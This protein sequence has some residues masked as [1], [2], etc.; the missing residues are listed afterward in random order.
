M[1]ELIAGLNVTTHRRGPTDGDVLQ[2]AALLRREASPPS[3]E[4]QRP[5]RPSPCRESRGREIGGRGLRLTVITPRDTLFLDEE[6]KV[7]PDL[8]GAQKLGELTEML[9]EPRRL[10]QRTLVVL[11]KRLR[12]F[13]SSI[14]R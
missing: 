2:G 11:G 3:W 12:S 9:G 4:R 6:Y 7:S 8:L 5:S 10:G 1:P 14:I 13:M